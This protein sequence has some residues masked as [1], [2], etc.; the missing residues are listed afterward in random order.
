MK[1]A[2]FQ[3]SPDLGGAEFYMANLVKEWRRAGDSIVV[4]TNYEEYKDLLKKNGA[5]VEH[6]PFVLDIFGN[7]RGL[8]KTALL[9]PLALPWYFNTLNR[10]L[11]GVDIIVLSNFTEKLVV[12]AIGRKLGIPVVWFE[13]PPLETVLSRNIGIPRYFYRKYAS[14]PIKIITISK[15]THDCLINETKLAK[16]KLKIIYP[17][18]IIPS[19]REIKRARIQATRWK[20]RLGLVGRRIIGNL[21]RL[22]REKGQDDLI[23]AFPQ[24]LKKIPDAILVIVGRGPDVSRLKELVRI[25]GLQ[26]SVLFL[27]FVPDRNV[28]LALMDVFVFT[29]CWEMEGFG[30]ALVEAMVMGIP[31][32]AANCGPVS[33]TIVAGETGVLVPP[34]DP[35]NLARAIVEVLKKPKESQRRAKQ[36]QALSQRK[37]SIRQSAIAVRKELMRAVGAASYDKHDGEPKTPNQ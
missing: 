31:A 35:V 25:Q 17:G 14:I 20:R 37:F 2:I 26:G 22:A 16:E 12:T 15:H 32:V 23:Q 11:G 19:D 8:I 7:F 3:Q 10:L 30:L 1:I 33:E 28:A 9:L 4:Y 5:K 6:L 24:I 34:N 27:G 29:S 21:S 13:Y 36:A 18:V